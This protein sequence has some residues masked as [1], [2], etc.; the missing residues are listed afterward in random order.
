L[1]LYFD[2]GYL[3]K[4]Y[5]NEPDGR[6]VRELAQQ[7]EGLYSS[8]ICIAEMA[9]LAHRKVR[10][11]PVTEVEA[12]TRRDLFLDDLSSGVVTAT[13]VT[14]RLLRRVEMMTRALPRTCYLRTFDA[15]HLVTV[16]D[17]GFVEIWTND[18]HMLAAAPH[19]RLRGRSVSGGQC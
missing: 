17:T 10:G 7:A 8:A 5:W 4:C 12:A 11:G 14:D 3:A 2:T 13:P 16:A 15:L 19:F 18:R 6:L 1:R 9:C